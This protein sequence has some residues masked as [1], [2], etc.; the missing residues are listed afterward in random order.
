MKLLAF[1]LA[2]N[3]GVAFGPAG[4][5]PTCQTVR[6]GEAGDHHSARFSQALHL[7]HTLIADLRPDLIV[8]EQPIAAGAK[9]GAD[10][11]L[12]AAGLRACVMGVARLR[13]VR[14]REYAV[15]T[16]RKHFIGDAKLKRTEAKSAV[17]AECLR[18][19]WSVQNDNEADAAALW[20]LACAKAGFQVAP[21]GLFSG[22]E[23]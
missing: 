3:T 6:L 22:A 8:V 14:I 12:M 23:T 20:D 13:S 1:D 9:G 11:I 4:S 2:T 7:T 18:R 10:R 17:I 21:G 16:V 19:G 15:A 5:V